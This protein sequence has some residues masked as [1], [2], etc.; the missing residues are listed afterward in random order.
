MIK[1]ARNSEACGGLSVDAANE[2]DN[3]SRAPPSPQVPLKFIRMLKGAVRK[4]KSSLAGEVKLR[5][6]TVSRLAVMM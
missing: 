3:G 5:E 4:K 6:F 2:M 1:F